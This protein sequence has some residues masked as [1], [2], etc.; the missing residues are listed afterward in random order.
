MDQCVMWRKSNRHRNQYIKKKWNN[1]HYDGLDFRGC[2]YGG[3]CTAESSKKIAKD[4]KAKI[5]RKIAKQELE[6]Q[7]RDADIFTN[8]ETITQ[9]YLLKYLEEIDPIYWEEWPQLC[10]ETQEWSTLCAFCGCNNNQC[11]VCRVSDCEH[12][13]VPTHCYQCGVSLQDWYDDL[14]SV[15]IDITPSTIHSKRAKHRKRYTDTDSETTNSS[16]SSPKSVRV[17]NRKDLYPLSSK[18]KLYT[19][20]TPYIHEL[21]RSIKG[22]KSSLQLKID[23]LLDNDWI[24]RLADY[25]LADL[26]KRIIY[27]LGDDPS[28]ALMYQNNPLVRI[29]GLEQFV[30]AFIAL[31][32]AGFTCLAPTDVITLCSRYCGDSLASLPDASYLQQGSRYFSRFTRSLCTRDSNKATKWLRKTWNQQDR[33]KKQIGHFCVSV[34]VSNDAGAV[35]KNYIPAQQFIPVFSIGKLDLMSWSEKRAS[36]WQKWIERFE[37]NGGIQNN[38]CAMPRV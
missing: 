9:Q 37:K 29:G 24:R 22:S 38:Q 36:E 14:M 34:V 7:L 20:L 4:I 25:R 3:W 19:A 13:E 28:V 33:A 35:K 1:S 26:D 10:V 11:G 12:A 30:S 31:N 17:L 27:T 2:S 32:C 18:E 15:P 21:F 6:Y 5:L 23:C 16:C 8:P